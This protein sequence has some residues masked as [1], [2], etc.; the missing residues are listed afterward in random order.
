MKNL[1]TV[2][3]F[4]DSI[5]EQIRFRDLFDSAGV[6]D[7]IP[8]IICKQTSLP[9]WIIRR[10]HNA[11]T[12]I[13]IYFYPT[14]GG[15]AIN[16]HGE[17]IGIDIV[18]GTIYDYIVYPGGDF[19]GPIPLNGS[20][21]YLEVVDGSKTWYSETFNV[22]ASVADLLELIFSCDVNLQNIYAGFEQF[23]YID[24]FLK[25]PEYLRED[26]G[27]KRD[28]MLIKEKQVLLKQRVIR[29][30]RLPEYMV[31]ALMLLPMMDYVTLITQYSEGLTFN[32]IRIKDPEW[33]EGAYGNLASLEMQFI[34]DVVIR[35]LSYIKTEAESFLVEP[36][37]TNI[38]YRGGTS[39]LKRQSFAAIQNQT[40]F[41]AT[42]LKLSS[43][44]LVLVNNA[45]QH[46]DT[47][48]IND[49]VLTLTAP[50]NESDTVVIHA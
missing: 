49:D 16:L 20:G 48:I 47:Y 17:D 11:G 37:S 21:Y 44:I 39:F 26:T 23:L 45:P 38:P 13:E 36:G 25:A 6:A 29:L 22:R 14:D 46:K 31:D 32:E 1:N 4:Y 7:V 12:S 35:K 5:T 2:F 15:D 42:D 10:D 19:N 27:D 8:L 33:S 9:P 24:Q 40:E 50:C 30:N 34:S 28:G 43:N 3:P 18:S 41:P